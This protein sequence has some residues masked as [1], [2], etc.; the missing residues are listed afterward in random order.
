M[1][2]NLNQKT[3]NNPKKPIMLRVL[4]IAFWICVAYFAFISIKSGKYISKPLIIG[5]LIVPVGIYNIISIRKQ[6][7]SSEEDK[8]KFKKNCNAQHYS[9]HHHF[10]CFYN[11][12]C[13]NCN[14]I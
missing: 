3:P 10:C 1:N 12:Y 4:R 6:Y 9:H 13:N 14:K 2:D 8:H 5:L 11:C 7:Q